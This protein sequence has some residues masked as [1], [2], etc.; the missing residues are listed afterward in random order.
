MPET[1]KLHPQF[2][3]NETQAELDAL[4]ATYLEGCAAWLRKHEGEYFAQRGERQVFDT[5]LQTIVREAFVR[6][7]VPDPDGMPVIEAMAHVIALQLVGQRDPMGAFG[8]VGVMIG[9]FMAELAQNARE[10][11]AS[12]EGRA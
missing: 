10:M 5:A 4:A 3:T 6:Q 9:V 12:T 8:D 7:G 1:N 11:M 2:V